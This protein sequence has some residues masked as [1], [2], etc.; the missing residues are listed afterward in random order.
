MGIEFSLPHCAQ[1]KR[2]C[3]GE[4]KVWIVGW[5][6]ELGQWNRKNDVVKQKHISILIFECLELLTFKTWEIRHTVLLGLLYAVQ[7]DLKLA[8]D[9]LWRI[10]SS[11]QCS[12]CHLLL[13]FFLPPVPL[14]TPLFLLS[15]FTHLKSVAPDFSWSCSNALFSGL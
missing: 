10:L 2:V 12:E 3:S 15:D 14:H 11:S 8:A 1:M 9:S 6:K 4:V 5:K 13:L 7:G